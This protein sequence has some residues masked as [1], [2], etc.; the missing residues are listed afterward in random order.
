APVIDKTRGRARFQ[1]S[2][3]PVSSQS[4]KHVSPRSP[5]WREWRRRE[6]RPREKA[7]PKQPQTWG[8]TP[9]PA[10]KNRRLS[11]LGRES[12]RSSRVLRKPSHADTRRKPLGSLV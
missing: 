4:P 1:V 9:P 7:A 11:L 10:R 2:R 5:A 12:G 8:Q 6:T 3:A